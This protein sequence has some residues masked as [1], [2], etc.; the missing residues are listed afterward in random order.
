MNTTLTALKGV[1]VGHATDADKL[2]GCTVV[3][4]DH[5]LPVVYT[6]LGGGAATF[7]TDML[8]NGKSFNRRHGL[9]IAGG[10]MQGLMSATSIMQKMIK[11]K[12]GYRDGNVINPSVS[13]AI[14]FDLGMF[15]DQYNPLL[16]EE[17]SDNASD[18][19]VERGNVGA[20][21]G[22]TVGKFAYGTGMK[23][24]AMKSGVGCAR[25][26]LGNGII[27]TALSVV[28]AVGNVI[29]KDGT[30][31]AGNRDE[32]NG[33]Q[34]FETISDILTMSK[35]NT[36]ISIV[37]I[38]VDLKTRE[39]YEKVSQMASQ[40]QVRAISPVNLSIDGDTVFVFSTEELSSFLSPIG[41]AMEDA[42][43]THNIAVDIIGHAAANAVQ[44]SIYDACREAKTI[45][46]ANAFAGII[47][48][49]ADYPKK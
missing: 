32:N 5:D 33:F 26:D 11:N 45:S 12:I 39:N 1:T 34:T 7:N 36:T 30:I 25:K 40:G 9:F 48:S 31:L 37:G 27:I 19:P 16:G 28:N 18:K 22:A 4:F 42:Y 23:M 46:F 49:T 44:E 2:T 8:Q 13:G 38:N 24:L 20:G 15:I 14:I 10:S 35:S 3:V 43:M 41:K 29:N 6:S 47:P 21:T 17:A